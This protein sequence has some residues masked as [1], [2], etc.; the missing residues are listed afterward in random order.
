[1]R[2]KVV[3]ASVSA[4][5]FSSFLLVEGL[6]PSMRRLRASSRFFLASRRETSGY[7]PKERMFS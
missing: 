2:P 6:T 7:L 1:M 5:S 4:V 3:R